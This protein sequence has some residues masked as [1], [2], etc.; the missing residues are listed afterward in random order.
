MLIFPKALRLFVFPTPLMLCLLLFCVNKQNSIGLR[1]F[2][3]GGIELDSSQ[4]WPWALWSVR[5]FSLRVSEKTAGATELAIQ[6]VKHSYMHMHHTF[7]APT[8]SSASTCFT[9]HT[10]ENDKALKNVFSLHFSSLYGG[11][12]RK[13][14]VRCVALLIKQIRIHFYSCMG[15]SRSKACSHQQW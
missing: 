7:T 11:T 13:S 12:L 10:T 1:G 3:P 14:G 6:N 5:A 9:A 15:L 8:P 4:P 2:K